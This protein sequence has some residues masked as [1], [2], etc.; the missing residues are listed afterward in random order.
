MSH[1]LVRADANAQIGTGHVM[2]C[3]A[4]AQAWQESGGQATFLL[5]TEAPTLESRLIKDAVEVAHISVQPGSTHD[6][7]QTVSLAQQKGAAWVVVD[8]Y[9]FGADY[10]QAIKQAGLRL[11]FVDDYGHA[12][13]YYADLVLNQNIYADESLYRN[14]E[15]YTRLL[16]GTQYALL[17][18][19][20]WP[21]RG[22]RREVPPVAHKVLVTLGGSD[23]D[24]VTFKVVQSLQQVQI[25]GLEAVVVVGSSNPHYAELQRAAQDAPI[26]IRLE[27]NV[28]NMP[29]LMAWA[30]VAVSAGGSTCWE[31][32]FMGLPSL[33]LILSSNQ[34]AVA[35]GLEATGAAVNLGWHADLAPNDIA[36]T[37]IRLSVAPDV[38]TAMSECG[39]KIV[40]GNGASRVVQ[41]TQD[42]EITLRPVQ[43]KD[44]RLIW[45]WANDSVNRAASFSSEPIP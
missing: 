19:E 12:S 21:W 4:L 15:P 7:H 41:Q 22:W 38:R 10:Q 28:T 8:G 20:F 40:D 26:P 30:D 42:W 35:A 24:N 17:R 2:R 23:L 11:V 16:L 1:L 29:E 27:S 31:L 45:E 6:A 34:R 14:R 3:L 32:V 36:Q 39:R 9:H 33:I 43:P 37:L 5:A 25:Q 44:C 13:H 18:R